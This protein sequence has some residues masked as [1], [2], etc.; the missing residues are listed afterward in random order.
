MKPDPS[1]PFAKAQAL[2][3]SELERSLEDISP[4]ALRAPT[5]L[6][7]RKQPAEPVQSP[8][9]IDED[10]GSQ[11]RQTPPMRPSSQEVR[12]SEPLEGFAEV[13]Q[14]P[15]VVR[16]KEPVEV[17]P[18]EM[19]TPIP[20]SSPKPVVA[21]QA[22]VTR[23]T[24]VTP[25]GPEGQLVLRAIFGVGHELTQ[26]EV[27]QRASALPG[28]FQVGV[29]GAAEEQAMAVLNNSLAR[30]G[31]AQTARLEVTC[32]QGAVDF[33]GEGASKLVVL[34]EGEYRPGIR[35]ILVLVARE[36]GGLR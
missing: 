24:P 27:L 10:F 4:S 18:L 5:R 15:E 13:E 22:P 29:F 20:V 31:L 16:V 28:I 8:F 25:A 12:L 35:E 7:E 9:S 3:T 11:T 2:Q 6:P 32:E 34:H 30:F 23:A 21:N 14:S 36:F 1:N 19:P 17:N 33:L 26:D